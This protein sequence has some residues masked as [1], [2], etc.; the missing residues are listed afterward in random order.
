MLVILALA[1]FVRFDAI[2]PALLWRELMI[3]CGFS[4]KSA[5]SV[6]K[7]AVVLTKRVNK[8]AIDHMATMN[9]DGDKGYTTGTV[10]AN[11]M[12][13]KPLYEF[14]LRVEA[15]GDIFTSTKTTKASNLGVNVG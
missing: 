1:T 9:I 4:I 3:W 7:S 8:D 6:V 2:S 13:V 14:D 5:P 10:L 15:G 11:E 12:V